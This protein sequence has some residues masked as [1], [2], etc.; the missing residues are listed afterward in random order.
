MRGRGINWKERIT[1]VNYHPG[2]R[3]DRYLLERYTNRL[4]SMR[5]NMH[6]ITPLLFLKINYFGEITIDI[7]V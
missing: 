4:E 6:R 7:G 5:I 3:M 1:Q 2:W